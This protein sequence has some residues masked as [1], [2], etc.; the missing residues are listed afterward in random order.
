MDSLDHLLSP[1]ISRIL[2]LDNLALEED[3][4]HVERPLNKDTSTPD[5]GMTFFIRLDTVETETDLWGLFMPNKS[6][7]FF[8]LSIHVTYLDTLL[9]F[10]LHKDSYLSQMQKFQVLEVLYSFSMFLKIF[11]NWTQLFL[12]RGIW[13]EYQVDEYLRLW[14]LTSVPITR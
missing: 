3:T 1:R 14:K 11:Q 10:E 7:V 2:A 13:I 5:K 8:H 9:K 6:C 12:Q 4:K